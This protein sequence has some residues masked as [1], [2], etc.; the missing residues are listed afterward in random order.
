[1]TCHFEE[2]ADDRI[3]GI[4]NDFSS[5]HENNDDEFYAITI[6]KYYKK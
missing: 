1:M 5:K 4:K 6:R 3:N 2:E